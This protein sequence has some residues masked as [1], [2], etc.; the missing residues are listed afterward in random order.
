MRDRW[1][2]RLDQQLQAMPNENIAPNH[3]RRI[4]Q[5]ESGEI[6]A[7]LVDAEQIK[8]LTSNEYQPSAAKT[9]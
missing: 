4:V 7:R 1:R 3:E 5:D 6:V 2:N 8:P 9:L